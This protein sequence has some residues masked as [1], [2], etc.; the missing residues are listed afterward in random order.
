MTIDHKPGH[1]RMADL[2]PENLL[3]ERSLA[4]NASGIRKVFDLGAKLADPINLSIGQP[5]FDVPANVRPAAAVRVPS[6]VS[7]GILRGL[8]AVL[9]PGDEVVIGDPYFVIY[10]HAVRLVGGNPAFGD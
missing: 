4:V 8:M 6:G 7:G 1:A 3:S 5:D 9:N 2:T 10:K